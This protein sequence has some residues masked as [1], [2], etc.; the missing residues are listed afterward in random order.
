MRTL[1]GGKQPETASQE[2]PPA[3]PRSR[4]FGRQHAN[5]LGVTDSEMDVVNAPTQPEKVAD[6]HAHEYQPG[7]AGLSNSDDFVHLLKCQD[8]RAAPGFWGH[9]GGPGQRRVEGGIL[10]A[11]FRSKETRSQR[12]ETDLV[13]P[14]LRVASGP[15]E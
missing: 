13:R 5:P 6:P 10:G 7:D 4:Q 3:K 12:E 1:A 14:F 2:I 8:A 15:D 11:A 9:G